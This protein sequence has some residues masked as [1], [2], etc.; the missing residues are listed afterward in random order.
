MTKS[1]VLKVVGIGFA[2]VCILSLGGYLLIRQLSNSMLKGETR[3]ELNRQIT[4]NML[5]S[6]VAGLE[7][8]KSLNH[9][10]PQCVG[11][12]FIDSIKSFVHF[13]DAYVYA[14]SISS[15]GQIFPIKRTSA[16]FDY[17][18]ISNTYLGAGRA[19]LTIIYRPMSMDSY[20][21]YG[22]GENSLDEGGKG[23]DIVR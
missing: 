2:F 6:C 8:F 14:D 20:N 21:L 17:M 9:H 5:D 11:K 23:D 18:H 1:K 16:T 3:I 4:N 22:V 19:E 13:S 10:Y 12:Y 15:A 7:G